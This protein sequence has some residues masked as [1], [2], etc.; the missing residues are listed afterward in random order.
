MINKTYLHEYNRPAY[1]TGLAHRVFQPNRPAPHPTVVMV[2]GRHGTEDATWVFAPSMPGDWLLVA[3]RAILPEKEKPSDEA[4]FSWLNMP[5]GRW[6]RLDE[7]EDA[8]TALA[9]FIGA[10]PDVYGADPSQ[11]YLLGFSQG[12]AASLALAMTHPGLVQGVMGLVGFA[13][14]L[15]DPTAVSLSGFPVFMAV[16]QRDD[17]VP[18]AIA[19]ASSERLR[20]LDADLSYSEY[21]VGHRLNSAGLKALQSWIHTQAGLSGA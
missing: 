13:P 7:F 8:V 20:Q 6:P 4:G 21:P 12:A 17:K 1:I 14:E 5:H 18:L 11:I 9:D 3:P 10:L 19:Q 2:H 15:P 16:G